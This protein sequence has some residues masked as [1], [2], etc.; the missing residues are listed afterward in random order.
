MTARYINLHFTLL[1]FT[2][3]LNYTV[4]EHIPNNL[5]HVSLLYTD[6]QLISAM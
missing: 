4:D 2:L 1:Y 3:H 5:E 6:L